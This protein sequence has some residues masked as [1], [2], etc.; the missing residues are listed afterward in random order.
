[1]AREGLAV[2]HTWPQVR[3]PRGIQVADVYPMLHGEGVEIQDFVMNR[4]TCRSGHTASVIHNEV[5]VLYGGASHFFIFLHTLDAFHVGNEQM[6]ALYVQSWL[7]E[8]LFAYLLTMR[9]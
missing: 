1:V 8:C 3:L 2:Q 5:L 7:V 9:R 6:L 4:F